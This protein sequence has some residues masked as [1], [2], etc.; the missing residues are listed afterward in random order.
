MPLLKPYFF[1]AL[2]LL[3]CIGA[4]HT[5]G[6][7]EELPLDVG[8]IMKMM[9]K[10]IDTTQIVI[11]DAG[12]KLNFRQ[13]IAVIFNN[14][15]M[16]YRNRK[17]FKLQRYTA[18]G[19]ETLKRDD[20]AIARWPR[21]KA[22]RN[23]DVKKTN[24]EK[25]RDIAATFS[26]ADSILVFKSRRVMLL[27]RKGQGIFKFEIDLGRN[28]IGD[29]QKEGDWRTPEGVYYVDNKTDREDKYYKSFWISYPNAIDKAYA[30]KR[31]IKPGV[32]VM[33]HGT[34]PDRV[35]AKD[36]TNGCIALSNKDMDTLFKYVLSGTLIDIRK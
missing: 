7:D 25:F 24:E 13:Y 27:Q 1:S 12:N 29:K 4:C 22:F 36:W 28:P 20:Y 21:W 18:M 15:G 33:I 5:P 6:S 10:G 11:D 23:R 9:P 34:Q 2:L 16:I 32:G 26:T 19:L 30:I 35:N 3:L 31:N 17:V 14:E 8:S